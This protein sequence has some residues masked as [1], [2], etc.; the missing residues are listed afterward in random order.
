MRITDA[1]GAQLAHQYDAFGNLVA[2]KDALQNTVTLS[3]D[4]RGRKTQLVDPDTGTWKYDYDALGQIVWQESPNQRA[5]AQTTTMAYDVLGRMTS[6]TEPEGT[7][8]WTYDQHADASTCTACIGKLGDVKVQRSASDYFTR[9]LVYDSLGRPLNTRTSVNGGPSFASSVAYDAAT[10]RLANQVY[11][12]GVQVTYAYTTRGYLQQ[13]Q[14][15]TAATVTPLPSTPGGTPVAGTTLAVG[16]ALWTANVVNAW[17][18]TE[19][20]SLANGVNS[21]AVFEAATGRPTDLSAGT[22]SNVGASANVFGHAYT[23]DSLNNLQTRIDRLSAGGG[24]QINEI[25][26]YADSLNRLTKYTVNAPAAGAGGTRAVTLQYNALGM[27]LYKSDVGVYTYGASGNGTTRPHAL[28]KLTGTAVTSYAYDANGNLTSASGGKYRS[29]SYN[30]F[31][32]PDSQTGIVGASGGSAGGTAQYTWS[33]DENHARMKETRTIT[34]GSLAG[35]RTTWNLHPDSSGGLG[36]EM[37]V[38]S[39]SPATTA[40]PAVTSHRHYLSAG[41]QVIGVLVS[42]GS[43]PALTATQTA[44]AAL[45]SVTLVKVEYWH[46]D[47]LG[48]L[49]ATT[50]HAGN[51][52]ARYA[53][54]PFGKRRNL[55]GSYD[56]NGNLVIDFSPATNAGTDRGFTGHE[57]LDDVGIVHMNG[58]LFDP[59]LGLFMQGDPF[60]QNP[61][62]L[63]NF[64][65]YGYC[66]NNPGTYT[67]PSGFFSFKNLF[68]AANTFLFSSSPV[69]RARAGFDVIHNLPG[70]SILDQ[71]V[72][73][74]A[75]ANQLGQAVATYFTFYCGGCGGYAWSAYYTY[76]ATGS[77]TASG[78]AVAISVASS[79]MFS[80]AGGVGEADSFARYAAHAAAGCASASISGGD[81]GQGAL[82]AVAGKYM[83]NSLS[84]MDNGALKFGATMVAGGTA[85]VIGGGK[86]SNGA[87]TASYGYIYNNMAVPLLIGAALIS[88]PVVVDAVAK[89]ARAGAEALMSWWNGLSFNE[90]EGASPDISADELRGKSRDELEQ[91]AKDKGLVQDSKKPSKWRDPVTGDERMRIDPGHVDPRTGQPY[92]N[93][94]A[95]VPH[96]H[97]YD[98]AGNKIRDP[99]AGNDPHFPIKP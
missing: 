31:N 37:E 78:R 4:L 83:T 47:H 45:G 20:Q 93:P 96:V 68:N 75:W 18:K 50:D 10:G 61:G 13:L 84:G 42:T 54:D 24:V 63:Q 72:A 14:L 80:A 82:S 48:S 51:V 21:K 62:D 64:N 56:P 49:A 27:L 23:W 30:S 85:S 74:N 6:R 12:T 58:R 7:T 22:G 86:F 34:G 33:Y 17:G 29:V 26:E 9:K 44:P 3:Y 98:P 77:L 28:Q 95:A 67:D 91:Q 59:T 88:N 87:L 57:H 69:K 99:L 8:T 97:G 2:T 60:I 5:L 76:Q 79:A 94:R 19:T 43:L 52:T 11:P 89:Q 41:G 53:Y 90:A 55:N 16:T 70:Q 46:K 65:R 32:L 39:P 38:N 40:N 25:F 35:T 71:F 81:C 73:S 15:A 92:D 36:Y 66:L 1:N